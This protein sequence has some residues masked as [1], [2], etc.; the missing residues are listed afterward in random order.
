MKC[1]PRMSKTIIGLMSGA[2]FSRYPI[3]DL[4]N[5]VANFARLFIFDIDDLLR[6]TEIGW[7]PDEV[8]IELEQLVG[9][10]FSCR[11]Q[12]LHEP[13]LQDLCGLIQIAGGKEQDDIGIGSERC[14]HARRER[15]ILIHGITGS[16]INNARTLDQNLLSHPHFQRLAVA[17]EHLDAF[18]RGADLGRQPIIVAQR[19]VVGRAELI[20]GTTGQIK[21]ARQELRGSGLSRAQGAKQNDGCSSLMPATPITGGAFTGVGSSSRQ[22]QQHPGFSRRSEQ[23]GDETRSHPYPLFPFHQAGE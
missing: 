14:P 19:L 17:Q 6:Q 12:H 1:E 13:V 16:K 15:I 4:H 22:E 2:V 10:L 5:F 21:L 20:D 7:M 11:A 18:S 3:S 9:I 8:F 23:C